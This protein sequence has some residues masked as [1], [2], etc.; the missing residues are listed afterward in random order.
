MRGTE[1]VV[2]K[3]CEPPDCRSI[4]DVQ[5]HGDNGN[6][7]PLE[8]HRHLVEPRRVD[9]GQHELHP[10]TREAFGEGEAD[11]AGGPRDDGDATGQELHDGSPS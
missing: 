2:C 6:A 8:Q 1:R 5:R 10:L 4:R 9:I 11:A 3:S 7:A